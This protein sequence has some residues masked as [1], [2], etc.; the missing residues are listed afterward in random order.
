MKALSLF[1]LLFSLLFFTACSGP[2]LGGKVKNEYYT[3]GKLRSS[4]SMTDSTGQNGVLKKYGYEGYLTSTVTIKNGVKSGIETW[5]DNKGRIIM[6]VPYA[7][8]EKQGLQKAYYP[9]GDVMISTT[10]QS[11]AKHGP[12]IA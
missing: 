1:F 8:G 6:K 5:Y 12:A 9:N 3:G 7:N 2:S 11:N 10:Y 4:F